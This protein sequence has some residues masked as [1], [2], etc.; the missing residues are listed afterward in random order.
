LATG[1]KPRAPSGTVRNQNAQRYP[2]TPG[3]A[4]TTA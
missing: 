1:K 3:A 2:L 4:V